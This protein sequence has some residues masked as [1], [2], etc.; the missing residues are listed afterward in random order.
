M[1]QRG[2]SIKHGILC[3]FFLFVFI[4][5]FSACTQEPTK[6]PVDEVTLQ[7]SW[8]HQAQFAGFY[9]ADL[10]GFYRDE[11]IHVT[12]R[13]TEAPGFDLVN[14]VVSGDAEF[15]ITDGAGLIIARSHKLPVT[16]IAAIYQR[17]PLSF[18]SLK[19]NGIRHPQ[20]FVG[21]R[22]RTLNPGG[23]AIIFH[24][25]LKKHN[26]DQRDIVFLDVGYDLN[27]LFSGEIDV[28]AGYAINEV[29]VA[30]QKGIAINEIKPND[31]GIDT[32]GDTLFTSDILLKTN[33]DLVLRFVRATLRG[34]QWAV[35]HP[36]DAAKMALQ[37]DDTLDS[38]HQITMLQA[39]IPYIQA[40]APIGVMDKAV[41]RDVHDAILDQELI[42]KPLNLHTIFS[43]SFVEQVYRD[44]QNAH[45]K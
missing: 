23:A 10:N 17:T 22:F 43:N 13:P 37:F 45:S 34:W 42:E 18:I 29:L 1:Q 28:W 8:K 2:N 12:L 39:S 5:F 7:L 21:K 36:Q 4:S 30:R 9:A 26:I 20:D 19:E 38:A 40:T 32:M 31:F 11:S 27:R 41:W 14:A 15:A 35:E 44:S 33:P 3:V 16:G 24:A 25:F 6:L